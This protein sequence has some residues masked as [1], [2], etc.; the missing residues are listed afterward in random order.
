MP[1][2]R[3]ST[4]APDAPPSVQVLLETAK[5]RGVTI[6]GPAGLRDGFVAATTPDRFHAGPW[7]IGGELIRYRADGTERD[8]RPFPSLGLPEQVYEPYDLVADA[9]LGRL[10]VAGDHIALLDGDLELLATGGPLIYPEPASGPAVPPEHRRIE[11]RRRRARWTAVTGPDELVFFEG[12]ALRRRRVR[13]RHR[14]RDRRAP[15]RPHRPGHLSR[16]AVIRTA[17]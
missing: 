11:P 13:L 12:R 7:T 6:T 2:L 4:P 14:R 15:D 17:S 1:L 16:P 9:G 8:R 10:V 5:T 3:I